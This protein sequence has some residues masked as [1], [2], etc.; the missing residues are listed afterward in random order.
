MTPAHDPVSTSL[1]AEP[2]AIPEHIVILLLEGAQRFT[3]KLEEAIGASEP[4]LV[5]YF[6]QKVMVIL[7]E[8]H[9]R[10]NHEQGGELVENL[11]RLYEWWSREIH[12]AGEQGDVCRLQSVRAQMG[13]MRQ[14]WEF[15]LFRG[16]GMS[17]SPGL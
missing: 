9:R 17:E 2:A 8:L 7:E 10:L 6:T 3:V 4:R 1:Q 16:E 5:G 14:A 13:D 11:I 15:V 12:M